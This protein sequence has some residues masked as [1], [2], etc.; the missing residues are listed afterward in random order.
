MLGIGKLKLI[1]KL[2]KL[3]GA[4]E[5][6]NKEIDMNTLKSFLTSKRSWVAILGVLASVSE[7]VPPK[8]A[9]VLMGVG[10]IITKA[11]DL[12]NSPSAP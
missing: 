1:P 5:N 2:I 12:F 7:I 4:V 3:A 6:L 11:L 10:T 9:A 8:T